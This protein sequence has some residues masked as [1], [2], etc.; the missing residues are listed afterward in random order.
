MSYFCTSSGERSQVLSEI[1]FTLIFHNPF[2]SFQWQQGEDPDCIIK[3]V[4]SIFLLCR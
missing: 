2:I 3:Q 1:I 4:G